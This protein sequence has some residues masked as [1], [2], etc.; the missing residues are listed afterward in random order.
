[1]IDE[2]GN[3]YGRL[4]VIEYVKIKQ[5]TGKIKGK[6]KCQCD[7]GN[8]AYCDGADLRRGHSTSCGCLQKEK[9]KKSVFIDLTGQQFGGLEVL[10]RDMNYQ[11][12]G[13]KTHWICKCHFCG[14]IKSIGSYAL[15]K[16]QVVSCG[17][18]R[19]K[20]E[21]KIAKMLNEN[22]I[23]FVQEFKF[24]GHKNRRFDFAILD[25]NNKVIRLIEFDGIQHY[26]KPRANHWSASSTLEE[27]QQRDKEKNDLAK[28]YNIPLVRIPYWNIDKFTIKDLINNDKFLVKEN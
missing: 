1:M 17:C 8:I 13:S 28:Q 26:Y 10:E 9:S 24:E 23:K 12:H 20:G 15:R 21:L 27:T 19:S 22:N 25:D 16:G 4:T 5:K 11:G 6:W 14:N 7:C 18:Q 2:T 3:R